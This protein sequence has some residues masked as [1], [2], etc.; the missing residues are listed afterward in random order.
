MDYLKDISSYKVKGLA[1]YLVLVVSLLVTC[2]TPS[3]LSSAGISE[4]TSNFHAISK[5]NVKDLAEIYIL[6]VPHQKSGPIADL[7]FIP[8]NYYILILF[9]WYKYF[10]EIMYPSQYYL[11]AWVIRKS[12]EMIS[13]IAVKNYCGKKWIYIPSK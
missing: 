2:T 11:F 10:S 8:S 13:I 9:F 6:Q 12:N 1:I 4:F 5:S 3:H 7:M